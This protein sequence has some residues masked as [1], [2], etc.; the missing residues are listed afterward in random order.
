M[1][2]WN[3]L[4]PHA[5]GEQVIHNGVVYEATANTMAIPGESASW[6]VISEHKQEVKDDATADTFDYKKLYPKDEQVTYKNVVYKALRNTTGTIPSDSDAWQD[7][8][9]IPQEKEEIPTEAPKLNSNKLYSPKDAVSYRGEIFKPVVNTLGATIEKSPELW[10]KKTDS[11]IKHAKDGEDGK[12][13]LQGPVGPQGIPGPQGEQGLQG[14]EGAKGPKGPKGDKGDKGDTG[15]Q[16]P[17]GEVRDRWVLGSGGYRNKI[18][19]QGSGTSLIKAE[20]KHSTGLKSLSAGSNVTITDDGLGT[21][22]IASTGGGGGSIP[23][24]SFSIIS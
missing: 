17:P 24:S 22:T 14:I 20:N 6:K 15:E 2:D 19:T 23:Q 13:G 11:G 3:K 4:N 7:I 12:D 21:L 1:K 16:G 18:I 5:K 9:T 10:A 8:K